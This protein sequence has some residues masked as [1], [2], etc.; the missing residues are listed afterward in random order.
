MRFI[1]FM[2]CKRVQQCL[3]RKKGTQ[4]GFPQIF[5][6]AEIIP[7][8]QVL[9]FPQLFPQLQPRLWLFRMLLDQLN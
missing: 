3:E 4:I 7:Q 9:C 8:L 2:G 6:S 1:S 5:L